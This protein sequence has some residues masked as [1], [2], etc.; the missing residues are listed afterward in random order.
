MI[1]QKKLLFMHGENGGSGG[2]FRGKLS[3]Q[4]LQPRQ[5]AAMLSGPLEQAVG[6][7]TDIS[8]KPYAV[9]Y[10]AA[11]NES[12][13]LRRLAVAL[14]E[15]N[16]VLLMVAKSSPYEDT[17]AQVLDKLGGRMGELGDQEL[18]QFALLTQDRDYKYDALQKLRAISSGGAIFMKCHGSFT[19]HRYLLELN[20]EDPA[21][22]FDIVRGPE[23][24]ER[25]LMAGPAPIGGDGKFCTETLAMILERA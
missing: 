3:G 13:T 8:G 19:F 12:A 22:L 24:V 2:V 1:G 6:A 7:L 9:G 21:E 17:R 4:D 23:E 14:L 18:F 11:Y 25:H 15:K 20:G 10:V 16:S 5:A